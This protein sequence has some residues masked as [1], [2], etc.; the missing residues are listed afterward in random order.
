MVFHTR[1]ETSG[2]N[3]ECDDL[4]VGDATYMPH[5]VMCMCVSDTL[6]AMKFLE[7]YCC[8]V[9]SQKRH[10]GRICFNKYDSLQPY[11]APEISTVTSGGFY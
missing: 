1:C 4:Q 6:H 2:F 8:Y 9:M 5:I 3:L 10:M 11:T 7:H